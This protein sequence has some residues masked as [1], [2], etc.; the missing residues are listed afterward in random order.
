ME[1]GTFTLAKIIVVGLVSLLFVLAYVLLLAPGDVD[2]NETFGLVPGRCS[3]R[4]A[5]MLTAGL[6]EAQSDR[7]RWV[8][9]VQCAALGL[10]AIAL[11]WCAPR[12]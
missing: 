12:E 10:L 4:T 3:V 5:V 1:K 11:I 2:A 7:G 8:K 6:K 9:T